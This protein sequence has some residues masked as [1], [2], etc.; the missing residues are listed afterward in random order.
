MSVAQFIIRPL[1]NN[2]VLAVLCF[3]FSVSNLQRH[4]HWYTASDTPGDHGL[5]QF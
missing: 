2:A 4:L 3:A 1:F 5:I